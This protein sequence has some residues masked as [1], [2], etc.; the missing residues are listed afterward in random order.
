MCLGQ[1][2]GVKE[3]MLLYVG[4]AI[5]PALPRLIAKHNYSYSDAGVD[6]VGVQRGQ[7]TGGQGMAPQLIAYERVMV[8]NLRTLWPQ[9]LFHQSLVIN[10]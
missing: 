7:G 3:A 10:R 5:D 6:G 2:R 8:K 9:V 1:V 4:G